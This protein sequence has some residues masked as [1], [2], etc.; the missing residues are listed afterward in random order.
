MI[1]KVINTVFAITDIADWSKYIQSTTQNCSK[2]R[3]IAVPVL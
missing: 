1:Y 2:E 3:C